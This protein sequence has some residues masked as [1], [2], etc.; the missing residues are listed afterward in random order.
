[1]KKCMLVLLGC[2]VLCGCDKKSDD[3]NNIVRQCGNY[4]VE[5][6]FMDDGAKMHAVINGDAVDMEIAVSASGARYVGVL[7]DTDVTLWGKGD[8]WT[9]FLNDD[10]P[11]ECTIK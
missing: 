9:M 3:N 1:M 10:A 7:N 4:T 11:I 5:M 8:A 2:V 6:S